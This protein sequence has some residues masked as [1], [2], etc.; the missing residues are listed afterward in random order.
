VVHRSSDQLSLTGLT[1]VL[2]EA[3]VWLPREA[4]EEELSRVVRTLER[5]LG[6]RAALDR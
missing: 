6:R 1:L 5:T 3:R 4:F 2:P